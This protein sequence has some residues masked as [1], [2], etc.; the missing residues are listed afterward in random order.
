MGAVANSLTN[1]SKDEILLQ[2]E[3]EVFPKEKVLNNVQLTRT[4]ITYYQTD[5]DKSKRVLKYL[6]FGDV[7]GCRCRKSVDQ[8]Y[9][10]KAYLT[11]FTYPLKKKY[12]SE[13]WVRSKVHVT[14]AKNSDDTFDGNRKVVEKW[15]RVILHCCR[16]L[17]VNKKGMLSCTAMYASVNFL[18]CSILST[19]LV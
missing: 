11:V 1:M 18:Y 4:G 6:H 13:K 14:F 5:V 16:Q 15:R 8:K 19:M 10:S 2:D 9:S 17:P 3:F 7:I 12:F